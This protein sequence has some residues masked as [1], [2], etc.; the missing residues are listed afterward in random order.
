M[1]RLERCFEHIQVTLAYNI[2][3]SLE[4]TNHFNHSFRYDP[5]TVSSPAVK[6]LVYKDCKDNIHR[7]MKFRA[8]RRNH[9]DMNTETAPDLSVDEDGQFLRDNLN[10]MEVINYYNNE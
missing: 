7:V 10:T 9:S 6:L 5:L 2:I 4:N 3:S 1:V 8:D